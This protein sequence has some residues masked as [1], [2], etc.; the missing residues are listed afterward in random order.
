MIH[1]MHTG[2]VRCYTGILV[3]HGPSKDMSEFTILGIVNVIIIHEL[4]NRCIV[5]P[6]CNLGQRVDLMAS[7]GIENN[8]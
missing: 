3:G 5:I 6:A 4:Y 8:L 2:P 7:I 1:G